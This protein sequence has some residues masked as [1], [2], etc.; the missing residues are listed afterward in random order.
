M[1]LLEKQPDVQLTVGIRIGPMEQEA[2][3]AVG[4]DSILG[5]LDKGPTKCLGQ[6]ISYILQKLK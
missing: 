1:V 3:V 2:T 4:A 5:W 6:A